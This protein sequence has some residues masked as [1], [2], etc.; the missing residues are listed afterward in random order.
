M[1][2]FILLMSIALIAVYVNGTAVLTDLT[3]VDGYGPE[4]H[5]FTVADADEV[6]T[7]YTEGDYA[8]ENYYA[9][10]DHFGNTVAESG[11]TWDSPGTSVPASITT[12]IIVDA[13]EGAPGVVTNPS[14]A[15]GGYDVP[16]DGNLTWSFGDNTETYE[17]WFGLAGN[18][19]LAYSGAAETASYAYSDLTLGETYNWQI[20]AQNST[21]LTTPGPVWSFIAGPA[22]LMQDGS[23]TLAVDESIMFFDDGGP[24]VN[25]ANDL[26]L[27]YTFT[28]PVGYRVTVEFL[29]FY[30]ESGY[31]YLDVYDGPD[32][33]YPLLTTLEGGTLPA[34]LAST[35]ASGAL[36]F[37]FISDVSLTY[38]GWEAI[39][40][41][42][43]IPT[44]PIFAYNPDSFSYVMDVTD[45]GD[46]SEVTIANTGG[47]VMEILATDITLSGD[48]VA[49]FELDISN[50]PAQIGMYEEETFMVRFAPQS[51]GTKTAAVDIAYDG[52]IYV[53]DLQGLAYDEN[54]LFEDFEEDQ[55]PP[56]GWS[57]TLTG[58]QRGHTSTTNL[59]LIINGEASAFVSQFDGDPEEMLITPIVQLDGSMNMLYFKTKGM[60]NG[61]GYDGST[62]KVMYQLE[63]TRT[64]TQIGADIEYLVN[65]TREFM[66]DLSA[67]P[68][69]LYRFGF[70]TTSAFNLEGYTSYVVVDDV[71]G[72]NRY[73]PPEPPG[74]AALVAPDDGLLLDPLYDVVFDWNAPSTGGQLD[75]YR[76]IIGTSSNV[77]SDLGAVTITIPEPTTMHTM[78]AGTYDWDTTYYWAV[79]PYSDA[80]GSEPNANHSIYSFTTIAEELVAE[81]VLLNGVLTGVDGVSLSWLKSYNDGN[82]QWIHWDG[83]Q[84]ILMWP[85]SSPPQ[86]WLPWWEKPSLR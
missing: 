67:L 4:Y 2:K 79:K 82:G 28:P 46:W 13:P 49:D 56:A 1:K 83:E 64:W 72:P 16:L 7:A 71:I 32:T 15:N 48:N 63:D 44:T 6:T 36:T 57:Q 27:T 66:I 85:P 50:F 76:L 51:T 54:N 70:A 22:I 20:I 42:E 11:G 86:I 12:P 3:I 21:R 5:D 37:N 45:V 23:T 31:D 33:T 65:D 74:P 25:Y 40:S 47:G 77:F 68:D 80:N 84:L 69:G 58:W 10:L 30:T 81:N 73:Y 38:L 29:D 19:T 35:D 8:D 61:L 18:M 59:Q 53:V 52:D 34:D 26:D 62:M 55:F 24:A 41:S 39:V 9:I 17:I 75:G 43:L 78:P 60:N 14:P